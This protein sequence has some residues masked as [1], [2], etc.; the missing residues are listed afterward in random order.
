MGT[1]KML[2]YGEDVYELA[3]LAK[4][5]AHPARVA[6][7]KH[8]LRAKQCINNDLVEELGLAQPTITRHLMELKKVN[9]LQ[10]TVDGTRLN[11]CI[12]AETWE[13]VAN[14]FAG[15]FTDLDTIQGEDCC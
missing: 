14:T 1:T 5:L 10:G 9:L 13:K 15:F 6:I 8:L 12:H 3:E 11:Y 2:D 7:L 4:A